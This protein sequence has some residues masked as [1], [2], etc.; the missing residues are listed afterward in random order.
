ML[1]AVNLDPIMAA[2]AH[3]LTG[4][5]GAILAVGGALV[6]GSGSLVSE[7]RRLP[8]DSDERLMNMLGAAGAVIGIGLSFVYGAQALSVGYFIATLGVTGFFGL[9]APLPF[10]SKL[11]DQYMERAILCYEEGDYQGAY[12]DASEVVR[13]CERY[14]AQAQEIADAAHQAQLNNRFGGVPGGS[15]PATQRYAV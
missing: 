11:N 7:K 4:G 2:V 3:G 1:L 6:F 10:V 9:L 14:R 15:S 12:E 13:S 8:I 5:F